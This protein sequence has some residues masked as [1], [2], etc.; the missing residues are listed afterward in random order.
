M[1]LLVERENR[2]AE[3]VGVCSRKAGWLKC[4]QLLVCAVFVLEGKA[5]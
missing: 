1:L 2:E 3:R 5:C 4:F